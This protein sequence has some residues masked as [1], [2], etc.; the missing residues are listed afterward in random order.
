MKLKLRG[1]MSCD[2]SGQ[3][4]VAPSKKRLLKTCKMVPSPRPGQ[5]G[6]ATKSLQLSPRPGSST[7]HF[8]MSDLPASTQSQPE[9]GPEDRA[10]VVSVP[11]QEQTE[12]PY[13]IVSCPNS[14][15]SREK[16]MEKRV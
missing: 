13:E 14:L 4:V 11:I 15:A 2:R 5:K 12:D 1:E 7:S 9:A 3:S 10:E 8:D 16:S 6:C